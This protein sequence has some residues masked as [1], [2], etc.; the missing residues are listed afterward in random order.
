MQAEVRA[1]YDLDARPSAPHSAE[2]YDPDAP[3]SPY[4]ALQ[5][6]PQSALPPPVAGQQS[7]NSAL[8]MLVP[9]QLPHMPHPILMR[10]EQDDENEPQQAPRSA[11]AKRWT[12]NFSLDTGTIGSVHVSMGLSASA[13]SVRLSS[14][15]AEI[16]VLSERLAARVEIQP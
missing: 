13:V 6:K 10:I 11:A 4:E 16:R 1:R 14:D 9:F 2:D 3:S 15:E 7:S 8:A 5:A 12:I